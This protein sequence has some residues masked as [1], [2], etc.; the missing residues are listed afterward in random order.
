[1]NLKDVKTLDEFFEWFMEWADGGDMLEVE[2]YEFTEE[3]RYKVFNACGSLVAVF[4]TITGLKT[5]K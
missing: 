3:R 2:A 1:M 4:S 5:Y